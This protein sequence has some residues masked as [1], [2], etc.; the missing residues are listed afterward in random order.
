MVF[1]KLLLFLCFLLAYWKSGALDQGLGMLDPYII[2]DPG[3]IGGTQD[4][5]CG[6]LRYRTQ[7]TELL[8]LV[9]I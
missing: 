5:K 4:P 6:A 7:P 9:F 3:P 1:Y 8:G 2:R